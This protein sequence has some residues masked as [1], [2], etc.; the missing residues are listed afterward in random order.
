M[1]L[2]LEQS[3][4]LLSKEYVDMSLKKASAHVLSVSME[5]AKVSSARGRLIVYS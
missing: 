3:R 5:R 1:T 2:D 4:S